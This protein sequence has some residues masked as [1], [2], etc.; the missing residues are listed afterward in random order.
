VIAISPPLFPSFSAPSAV[1]DKVS[2][3]SFQAPFSFVGRKNLFPWRKLFFV[4]NYRKLI[5]SKSPKNRELIAHFE[6]SHRDAGF[7]R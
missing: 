3:I 4:G 5:P 2:L 1:D 7:E 6:W